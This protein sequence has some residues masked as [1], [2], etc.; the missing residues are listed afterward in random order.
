M[1]PLIQGQVGLL[2]FHFSAFVTSE[3]RTTAHSDSAFVTSEKR[4]TS[5]ILDYIYVQ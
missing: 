5:C 3:K 4:T 2:E 1:E